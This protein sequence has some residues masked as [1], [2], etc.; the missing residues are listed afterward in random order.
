MKKKLFMGFI[1]FFSFVNLALSQQADLSLNA[2]F[3]QNEY[4][5]GQPVKLTV[6]I[7][8]NSSEEVFVRWSSADVIVKSGG[9]II[10]KRKGSPG[11]RGDVKELKPGESWANQLEYTSEYF[12]MPSTGTYEAKIIYKNT[13]KKGSDLPYGGGKKRGVRQA[14]KRD[15]WT[16]VVETMATLK[17]N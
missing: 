5:A 4:Q 14:T 3:D 7:N 15:L 11:M 1:C 17:I 13:Q 9:E 12:D 6:T 16:G 8:N 10:F 2:I